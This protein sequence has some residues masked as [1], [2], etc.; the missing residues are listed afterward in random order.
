M[1]SQ[2]RMEDSGQLNAWAVLLP[3]KAPT[4]L[5]SGQACEKEGFRRRLECGKVKLS[6]YTPWRGFG[7]RGGIAANHA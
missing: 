7:R 1:N 5:P 3:G 6:R 4:P 2:R